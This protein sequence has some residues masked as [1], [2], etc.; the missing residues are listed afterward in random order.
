[1]PR[2]QKTFALCLF[3]CFSHSRCLVVGEFQLSVCVLVVNPSPLG[4]SGLRVIRKDHGS[5]SAGVPDHLYLHGSHALAHSHQAVRESKDPRVVVIQD[6]DRGH[7]RFHQPGLGS[8]IRVITLK[9]TLRITDTQ[10][11]QTHKE[12]FVFLKDVIVDDAHLERE[13]DFQ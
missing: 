4:C 11:Q 10:V 9:H 12:M 8:L 5:T 1:M 2:T 7:Q 13:T 3:L 6:G